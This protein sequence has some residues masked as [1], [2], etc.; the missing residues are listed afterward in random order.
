[1]TKSPE[2][3]AAVDLGSNSFHMVVAR[4]DEGPLAVLDRI[5][6]RVQIAAGLGKDGAISEEAQERAL[7]CLARF[8]QRLQSM[9]PGSVRVVGTN[10]LRRATNGR[11]FA[12]LAAKT[13]G[14]PVEILSGKEEARLIYVGVAHDVHHGPARRLVIDV[15]GGSTECILGEG[16]EIL[17]ADSLQMGCVT[18][19][20]RHFPD[21]AIR[22]EGMRKAVI[23]ARLELESIERRYKALGWETCIGSSG[24]VQAIDEVLRAQGW[25]DQGV[26][27]K[28][29][30]RLK[31]ALVEAG[32]VSRLSLEGLKPERASVFAGGVAIVTAA[33]DAFD[34]E[35]M[36]ASAWALQE[37][38]L[39]DLLGRIQ[40][41]DVRDQTVRVFAERY[42]VDREHA[43]RVERTALGFLDQVAKAWELGDASLR[44]LVA[45]AARLHEIGIS[46]SYG[47]Y[48]KHGAYLATH[49]D[50]PGF[51]REDQEMLAAL[52]RLHR[53]RLGEDVLD[54][55]P[56][57]R[58]TEALRLAVLLR[59][60]VRLNR[61]RSPRALP[62]IRA[63]ADGRQLE[64]SF[65]AT[66]LEGHPLT[67]AELEE[68]AAYLAEARMRLVIS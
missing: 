35:R 67:R 1:M 39:Y 23:A 32:D 53:R 21:G 36:T 41:E 29:L 16:F 48:H 24:T 46:V 15:G 27:P 65:P 11:A 33:F 63:A 55:L 9:P 40:H 2:T 66:W 4:R 38:V 61:S 28:S 26:T 3:V 8:G 58:R 6:E 47:G 57:A 7:A 43:A 62:R 54:A 59:L 5:K 49:S 31:K 60:G 17:T 12:R 45:W 13:L 22:R 30:R 37:G 51:S 14:H 18:F 34:I 64:L 52:I 42:Q 44:R 20:L 50:M 56:V 19:S 25:S 68:E 10:T